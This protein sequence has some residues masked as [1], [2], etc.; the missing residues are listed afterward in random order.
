[1]VPSSVALTGVIE[2][3]ESVPDG[4]ANSRN[5]ESSINSCHIGQEGATIEGYIHPT[6]GEYVPRL[7]PEDLGESK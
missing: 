6:T 5:T 2:S 4:P 1:M 7:I 3:T